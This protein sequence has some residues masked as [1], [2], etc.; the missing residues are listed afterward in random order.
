VIYSYYSKTSTVC[1]VSQVLLGDPTSE[2][3]TKET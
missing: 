3:W 1:I 2:V